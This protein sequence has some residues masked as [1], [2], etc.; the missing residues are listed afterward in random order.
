MYEDFSEEA[1]EGCYL[2][3]ILLELKTTV[4]ASLPG[5]TYIF[6]TFYC[7]DSTVLDGF[8]YPVVKVI[9]NKESPQTKTREGKISQRNKLNKLSFR[10]IFNTWE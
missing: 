5:H 10:R 7:M 4:P 2:V 9:V 8:A 3:L 6:E 1:G